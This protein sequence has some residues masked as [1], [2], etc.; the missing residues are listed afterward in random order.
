MLYIQHTSAITN[1]NVTRSEL[2]LSNT[3]GNIT[4]ATATR[5]KSEAISDNLSICL[6][7]NL[8]SR[9]SFTILTI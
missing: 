7:F 5:P 3:A 6:S 4:E 9:N 2:Y 1:P 8:N